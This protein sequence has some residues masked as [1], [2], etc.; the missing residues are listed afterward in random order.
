MDDRVEA[1]HSLRVAEHERPEARAIERAVL[2]QHPVA[3]PAAIAAS[4]GDLLLHV[5]DHLIRIDDDGTVLGE[6]VGDRGFARGDASGEGDEWHA[7]SMSCCLTLGT[8]RRP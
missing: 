8:W 1:R 7:S 6:A 4:T 2:A 5:A 3:E